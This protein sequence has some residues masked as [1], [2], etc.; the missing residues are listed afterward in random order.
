MIKSF[1]LAVLAISG[2][3]TELERSEKNCN[4]VSYPGR[5]SLTSENA[6]VTA[7]FDVRGGGT[8][9]EFVKNILSGGEEAWNK[10]Y[11]GKS[12]TSWVLVDFNGDVRDL[13][14]FAFKSAND[15]PSR[16]P[17]H[18][19]VYA[20]IEGETDKTQIGS[21]DLSFDARWE[22]TDEFELNVESVRATKVEFQFYNSNTAI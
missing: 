20:W 8:G 2:S 11:Q 7:E 14:G 19:D 13:T 3:A 10:W 5:I 22:T 17:K 21:Y 18:V 9:G 16:D 1:T 15:V 6:I 12:A 4:C